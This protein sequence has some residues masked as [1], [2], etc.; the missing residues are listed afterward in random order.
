[1]YLPL[2]PQAILLYFL[3]FID[4]IFRSAPF[5]EHGLLLHLH[6]YGHPAGS[7]AIG[8]HYAEKATLAIAVAMEQVVLVGIPVIKAYRHICSAFSI[9]FLR[10][11][12]GSNIGIIL[13]GRIL[14]RRQANGR[15]ISRPDI[16]LERQCAHHFAEGIAG[17]I[18]ATTKAVHAHQV[19]LW[20]GLAVE[21]ESIYTSFMCWRCS[22]RIGHAIVKVE[23]RCWCRS[24]RALEPVHGYLVGLHFSVLSGLGAALCAHKAE[25]HSTCGQEVAA[26]SHRL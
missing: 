26:S 11:E 12:N 13:Y 8:R 5:R 7:K 14:L 19:H 16:I 21:T 10:L 25:E 9:I 4:S 17:G 22:G 23:E 6:L 1:M 24:S 20:Q 15:C 18:V 3:Q 2:L